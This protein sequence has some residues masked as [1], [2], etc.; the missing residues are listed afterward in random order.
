MRV[1]AWSILVMGVS[2]AIII[3]LWVWFGH[4]G[5]SFSDDALRKQQASLR[6]QYGLPPAPIISAKDAEVPPSLRNITK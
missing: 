2:L 5:P 6:D 4:I 3:L 1:V